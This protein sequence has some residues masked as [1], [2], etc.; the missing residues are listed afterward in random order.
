MADSHDCICDT[1]P[2]PAAIKTEFYLKEMKFNITCS[3]ENAVAEKDRK[4][5]LFHDFILCFAEYFSDGG[6]EKD[7]RI[8]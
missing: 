7:D 8:F 4:I 1:I 3:S 2:L 5:F 6:K